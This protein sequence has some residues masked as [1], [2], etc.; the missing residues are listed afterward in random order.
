MKPHKKVCWVIPPKQNANFVYRM[1]IVLDVYKRPHNP[2]HPVLC[3]D[4]MPKQL[5]SEKRN[6][7]ITE[8][9]TILYDYEYEREGACDIYVVC[10]PLVGKRYMFV[11]DN[12]NSLTWAR[13][14]AEVVENQYP[15]AEKVTIVQDN[16][17]AHKPSAMY[18]IFPAEKAHEILSRIEFVYTPPH[19]SWLNMAEIE[20]SV[21]S[22]QCTNQRIASKEDLI[23]R[24]SEW[25]D[26]RNSVDSTIDWQFTTEDARIKLRHLYPTI[27]A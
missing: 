2:N 27:S 20:F 11:E 18:E 16:L 1:E 15:D 8:S 24:V 13:I 10:E 7:I 4:E 9:G 6:P 26:L 25:Q 14:V 22:R 19:A 17:S 12:H 5:V 3:L 21:L 23:E